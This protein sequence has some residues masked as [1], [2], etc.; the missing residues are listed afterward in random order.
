MTDVI[1]VRH[2]QV[3]EDAQ[4]ILKGQAKVGLSEAGRVEAEQIPK[5]QD[6]HSISEIYTSPLPRSRQT[7]RIIRAHVG[8][9]LEVEHGLKERDFGVWQGESKLDLHSNLN[10]RDESITEW[11][12]EDGEI[13]PEFARR[14]RST[15]ENIITQT[16]GNRILLVGHSETNNVI[17]SNALGID[18]NRRAAITQQNACINLLSISDDGWK[19]RLLNSQYHL[20]EA[21]EQS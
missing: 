12:P 6:V 16:T 9:Q 7:A 4:S 21:D 5:H 1:L 11:V 20:Y 15:V 18:I 3:T 19:V 13:W 8:G 2:G 17:I 10:Q 14:V